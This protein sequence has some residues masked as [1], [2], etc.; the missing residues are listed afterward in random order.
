MHFL[1]MITTLEPL[2]ERKLEKYN[3][4]RIRNSMIEVD[5]QKKEILIFSLTNTS[6]GIWTR[7]YNES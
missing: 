1:D 2:L 6:N 3:V 5:Q 4:S 7:R